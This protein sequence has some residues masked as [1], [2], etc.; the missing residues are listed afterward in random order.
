MRFRHFASAMAVVCS[1]V[2]A[3]TGAAVQAYNMDDTV[4]LFQ[5]N[6]TL[7]FEFTTSRPIFVT[8][9]GYFDYRSPDGLLFSHDVGIYDTATQTLL[10]GLSG[11]VPSGVGSD[12]VINSSTVAFQYVDIPDVLLP[13]GTYRIAG[14]TAGG[15]GGSVDWWSTRSSATNFG[16]S[17]P[18]TLGNGYFNANPALSYPDEFSNGADPYVAPNFLFVEV[19]EPSS[20]T[21]FA[22][23]AVIGIARRRRGA[24]AR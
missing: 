14:T 6:L 1:L 13:A 11:T 4:P 2:A 21:I 8:D 15:S 7:G 23:A 12:R 20:L 3:E 10:A 18:I 19:P 22:G 9:L 17:S 5:G 16:V 24:R